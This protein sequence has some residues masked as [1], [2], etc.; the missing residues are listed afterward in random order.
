MRT[1][2]THLLADIIANPSTSNSTGAAVTNFIAKTG[3]Y[4]PTT[5]QRD[6]NENQVVLA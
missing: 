2:L 5:L 1:E 3:V 6:T 4:S